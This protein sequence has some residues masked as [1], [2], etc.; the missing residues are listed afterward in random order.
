MLAHGPVSFARRPQKQGQRAVRLFAGPQVATQWELT[1][2]QRAQVVQGGAAAVVAQRPG[3]RIGDRFARPDDRVGHHRRAERNRR[4]QA[5]EVGDQ[6]FEFLAGEIVTDA[7]WQRRAQPEADDDLAA[8]LRDTDLDVPTSGRPMSKRVA[9]GVP[10]RN[11]RRP[12]IV[13]E[14]RSSIGGDADDVPWYRRTRSAEATALNVCCS[15]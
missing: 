4:Q 15:G 12:R 6:S 2:A 14:D 1:F 7:L 3:E 5:L 11:A 13:P 10:S 8:A 9:L